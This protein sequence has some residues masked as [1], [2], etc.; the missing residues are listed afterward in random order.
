MNIASNFPGGNIVVESINE[1]SVYLHQDLRDN[2]TDWFYWYFSAQ[3]AAGRTVRFNFTGSRAF[4][5]RGPAFSTDYGTTWNWLGIDSLEGNSFIY[6]FGPDE[7]H[8]LFSVAIPYTEADWNAFLHGLGEKRVLVGIGSLGFTFQGR[9]VETLRLGCLDQLPE[10][11]VV[12]TARH[13]CCE[14]MGSYALEGLISFVLSDDPAAIR[15]REQTEL[16]VVPFMDKDGVENGDQGKNRR[17]RDHNRDYD[18]QSFHRETAALRDLLPTWSEGRLRV[19]LDFH[20]PRIADGLNEKLYSL[21]SIWTRIWEQQQQFSQI[22]ER[23]KV[24]PL[25]F[26][27]SDDLPWGYGWNIPINYGQGRS[28]CDWMADLPEVRLAT[29][30]E[31]PYATASGCEVNRETARAFGADVGRALAAYL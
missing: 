21:G 2:E 16:L 23:V 8:T 26:Y 3:N 19:A 28:F 14:T 12:V 11:R 24:G 5:A 13:H 10:H 7:N 31:I 25:P 20:C 6:T 29:S 15:L 27:A 17:P 30:Y 4:T 22:L 9:P 18:N 1:D